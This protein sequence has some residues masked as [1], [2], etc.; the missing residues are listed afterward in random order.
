MPSELAAKCGGINKAVFD[1][2]IKDLEELFLPL[3]PWNLLQAHGGHFPH[4]QNAVAGAF[5]DIVTVRLR[6]LGS[7]EQFEFRWDESTET[8]ICCRPAVYSHAGSD[9]V[10][11]D[12]PK[13]WCKSDTYDLIEDGVAI[14]RE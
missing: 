10:L 12:E 1:T 6:M 2:T 13:L 7:R 9:G 3:V 11:L 8:T 5:A 14:Y 4:I